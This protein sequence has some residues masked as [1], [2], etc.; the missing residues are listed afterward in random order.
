[1]AA[2]QNG[3]DTG[4]TFNQHLA[5]ARAMNSETCKLVDKFSVDNQCLLPSITMVS[6]ARIKIKLSRPKVSR[7]SSV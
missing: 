1:M 7:P 3:I 2:F 5:P 6:M 4:T